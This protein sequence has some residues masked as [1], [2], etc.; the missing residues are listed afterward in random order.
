MTKGEGDLSRHSGF[1]FDSLFEL[2]HSDFPESKMT[3]HVPIPNTDVTVRVATMG[4]VAFVDGLQ[5]LHR[6]GLGFMATL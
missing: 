2:R 3:H 1:G 4:D 6:E 5:K